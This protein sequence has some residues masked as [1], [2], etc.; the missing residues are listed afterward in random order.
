MAIETSFATHGVK[1]MTQQIKANI[2]IVYHFACPCGHR[3][4]E[5]YGSYYDMTAYEP[6]EG[7]VVECPK[8]KQELTLE[9]LQ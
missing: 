8:C 2:N 7:E 3:W 9:I 6:E 5:D 4:S 1:Y